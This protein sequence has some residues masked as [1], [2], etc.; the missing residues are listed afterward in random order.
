MSRFKPYSPDQ[1]YLL[2]PGVK[3][4][5]GEGHLCFFVQKVVGRLDLTQFE[6][7]YSAEGGELYAPALMLSVWLYAYATGLTSGRELERRMQE[8]LPLR[9]L[10]GGA[11]PDH[12]ALS[13]FRR[14]HRRGINDVFTQVLE[15]VRQQGLGKLGV[16]AIDSTRIKASNGKARVDSGKQ[17][18]EQRTKYRRQIRQWQKRADAADNAVVAQ[19][20]SEQL[21][22][23]QRQLETIPAR[24]E[25]LK[26]SG[27]ERLPR[28][29]PDARVLCKRG[30]SVVGYTADLAVSQ[31]HFI[32]A[33]RVTQAATDNASLVPMVQAVQRQCRERPQQVVADSG[34]YSNDNAAWME[35]EDIEGY[36]PD[37]NLAAALNRG[38]RVKGR[39]R[40]PEMKRMRAKFRTPEGRARYAQ[41]K[42]M[43]EGPFGTL[44][45]E[46]DLARFRL[47]GLEKVGIEFSL[48]AIG[49]NL[50]RWRAE[51]D[52][53]SAVWC[54]RRARAAKQVGSEKKRQKCLERG[55]AKESTGRRRG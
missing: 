28:T 23:L 5:L 25:K 44:K 9:Y 43:V 22:R 54:R 39:A 24:L 7:V 21:E 15:F 29:D 47:R 49:Y 17:L 12:W 36:I 45:T 30:Q 19:I 13:A 55:K 53:E 20:A 33:Q 11:E 18:R 27:Q 46:R 42:G 26:K 31:D 48:S 51:Q 52:P 50:T 6:Q 2:P 37:S 14:K 34:L 40:A 1:V 4:V 8:D 16:V 3:D 10:G 38:T 41:R 32:V 35:A